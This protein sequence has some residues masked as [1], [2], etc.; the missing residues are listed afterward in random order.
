MSLYRKYRPQKFTDLIGED[1]IKGTL[2]MAIQTGRVGHAYLFAGPRGIGKT[3]VARLLAKAVN[4]Q[5]RDELNSAKNGEPCGECQSC[6]EITAGKNLDI[7]EID[8]ASNRGID[9]IRDLREKVRFAPSF[10]KY[11]FY[12]IDEIHMLTTPAFNALLKTLEEPPAHAIFALA[13]TEPEKIPAT[14][15]SRVQRFDFR[16]ISKDDIV[17]NLKLIAKSE[18][19]KAEES[20]LEAIAV[21]GEGSH[22]DAISIFE[23]V[24]SHSSDITLTQ[25]QNILGLSKNREI[26][27]IV[28]DIAGHDAKSAI[29]RV[30]KLVEDG[31]DP[32]QL[33][34]EIIETFRKILLIKISGGD[35]EFEVTEEETLALTKLSE[36]FFAAELNQILTIFIAAGQLSKETSVRTLPLEMGIIEASENQKGEKLE[37]L[38]PKQI[39]PKEE[40]FAPT[41][42]NV[43]TPTRSVGEIQKKPEPEKEIEKKEIATEIPPKSSEPKDV[44]E[45]I[46]KDVIEKVKPHNHTLNALLRDTTICGIDGEKCL[47]NV[48]FKFH[49]DKISEP[50]NRKIIEDALSHIVGKKMQIVC[51]I[52]EK[53]AKPKSN[54]ENQDLEKAAEEIFETE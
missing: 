50:V 26:L 9:E 1:H 2:L 20:A 5:K 53:S 8:A 4:C 28:G 10:G 40:K 46:W 23:Q 39:K 51:Q 37:A 13:T 18:K 22:R 21:A 44:D 30:G 49:L 11:K 14:I 12:I 45:K 41:I 47:I 24:A 48:R 36:K 27:E 19:L 33:V 34:K 7:I 32:A 6:L 43:G 52:A 31:V 35:S 3:T 16:R 17:K 38:N 42:S 29:D 15:L 54:S 25:V